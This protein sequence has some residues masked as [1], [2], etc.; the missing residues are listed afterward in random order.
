LV[1]L[2]RHFAEALQ[3]AN[4]GVGK[5]AEAAGKSACA[6]MDSNFAAQGTSCYIESARGF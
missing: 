5:S 6:T 2:L 4:Q 3:M 1:L